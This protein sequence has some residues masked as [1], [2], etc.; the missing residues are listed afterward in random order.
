MS[1]PSPRIHEKAAVGFELAADTY[2]RGRPAYPASAV[3]FLARVLNLSAGSRIVELGAGTGKFTRLLAASD[4]TVIA[5][6]PVAAMRRKLVELLPDITIL[7]G[8]AESIPVDDSSADAVMA[9]SAFHWFRARESLGEIHRVLKPGGGLGLMWNV[10]DESVDWV[11]EL[12]RIVEPFTGSTPRYK[13]LDWMEAFRDFPQFSPLER[14]EFSHSEISTP[15]AIVDRVAS[16]SFIAALP[17]AER[18]A[19]LAQVAAMLQ[20]NALTRNRERI[21]FPY[22]THVYWC[23]KAP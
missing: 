1:N 19:V 17:V 6:E 3:A 21:D 20:S 5:V 16:I 13:S 18:Q 22:R 9:A 14:A 23:R 4:A 7:D 11:R 8:T 15:A 10:R 12:T 2:E